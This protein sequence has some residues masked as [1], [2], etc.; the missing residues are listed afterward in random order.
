SERPRQYAGTS[1]EAEQILEPQTE[2]L[3]QVAQAR[4][5]DDRHDDRPEARERE[6]DERPQ[7][8]APADEPRD[9]LRVDEDLPHLQP[10]QE[11]RGHA[12]PAPLQELDHVEMRADGDDQL[13]A[14]LVGEEER[15]VLADAE[16]RNDQ[17]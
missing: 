1:A 10:G 11:R 17:V 14:L 4:R 16:R 13:R 8:D 7:P 2:Q 3:D 5:S 9:A 15:D 6:G 12:G